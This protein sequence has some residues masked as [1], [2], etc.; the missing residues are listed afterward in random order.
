MYLNNKS[1]SKNKRLF[2]HFYKKSGIYIVC[3]AVLFIGI[4]FLT[5][6]SPAYR[7]S[8]NTITNWTSDL[9]SSIFL[10]LMGME[11]K[12]FEEAYPDDQEWPD[13]SN[14]LFEMA[15]NIRP[16]D[17]RS[18]LGQEL[19][20]FLTFQNEIIVAGEGTDYT[21]LPV[22]SA[23]P[24][25]DILKEREAV[26]EEAEKEEEADDEQEEGPTTGDRDV[27][28]IYNTHNRESFLPH[29]PD[30]DDPD[31]AQHGEVNIGKVSERFAETLEANGVGTEVDQTDIMSVLN[32]QDLKYH[33]SYTASREVVQEAFAGN[34]DFQYSFDLHRDAIPGNK[35]T[36]EIDGDSYARIMFVVG[37]KYEDYEKNLEIA[38]ELHNMIEA[39]YPGLS[40]GV[41]TKKGAGENGVY[42][43]DMSPNAM[44][45][46]FGG[47]DN[48]L[49]ELY[50]TADA[51]A[52]VFSDYYWD[53]EK[54]DAD[55]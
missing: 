2:R 45:L 43:Q 39:K 5:T 19:P 42:N 18:L 47:V 4:G 52:E 51:V 16:S 53:A 54:V 30:T 15:T 7:F 11:N 10:Y 27:V 40:R 48:N 36:K 3:V 23:P 28:F 33:E 38:N 24:L 21:N 22:E 46:E 20:G 9:D 34:D 25:E 55:Q 17:T 32:D 31:D 50:R 1:E 12:A 49:D 29:L 44:L 37:A 26:V 41:I 13:I 8:S 35:T 14:M 6:V